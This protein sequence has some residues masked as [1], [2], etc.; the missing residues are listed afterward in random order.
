MVRFRQ[1]S[2]LV[3]SG[4]RCHLAMLRAPAGQ[5]CVCDACNILSRSSSNRLK[6]I[7]CKHLFEKHLQALWSKRHISCMPPHPVPLHLPPSPTGPLQAALHLLRLLLLRAQAAA[8]PVGKQSKRHCLPNF[9]DAA[10]S[11]LST[12]YWRTHRTCSLQKR[13]HC[14]VAE[15][16]LLEPCREPSQPTRQAPAD[17]VPGMAANY[18]RIVELEEAKREVCIYCICVN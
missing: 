2:S 17:F 14:F 7:S 18:Q 10:H 1:P 11:W 5:V 13:S 6:G 15:H 3:S 4:R 16:G 8:M 12:T 9:S